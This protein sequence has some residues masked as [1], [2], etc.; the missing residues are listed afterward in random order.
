V[1]RLVAANVPVANVP[2]TDKS[3]ALVVAN[4]PLANF[5]ETDKFVTLVVQANRARKKYLCASKTITGEKLVA[6]ARKKLFAHKSITHRRKTRI[7]RSKNY[8]RTTQYVTSEKK[9]RS[10]Q[11]H[12]THPNNTSQNESEKQIQTTNQIEKRVGGNYYD[13]K[14]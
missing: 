7:A 5:P 1:I 14:Q 3:V 13:T 4:V 8:L 10:T 2:S 11:P 6:R 12:V 9:T